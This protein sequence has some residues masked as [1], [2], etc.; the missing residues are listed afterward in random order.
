MIDRLQL[1]ITRRLPGTVVAGLE[2]LAVHTAVEVP[3]PRALP[4]GQAHPL[5]IHIG[6]GEAG[7]NSLQRQ[8]HGM[9]SVFMLLPRATSRAPMRRPRNPGAVPLSIATD[10]PLGRV[11]LWK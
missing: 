1:D 4:L 9:R 11:A 10:L 8:V 6:A 2:L 5:G 3:G 7:R